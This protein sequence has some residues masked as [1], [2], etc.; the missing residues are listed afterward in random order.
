MIGLVQKW[1]DIGTMMGPQQRVIKH[2]G[3]DEGAKIVKMENDAIANIAVEL[4]RTRPD[5]NYQ[6]KRD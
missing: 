1:G 4:D 3:A 6:P 5:L 2:F